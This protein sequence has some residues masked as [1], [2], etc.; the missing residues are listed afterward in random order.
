MT[1][2]APGLDA[3]DIT[4][5]L[6]G[7]QLGSRLMRQ[8]QNELESDDNEADA[9]DT[10]DDP[11][12]IANDSDSDANANYESN[13]SHDDSSDLEDE[14][15]D[16]I[17]DTQDQQ[18]LEQ[19]TFLGD[20]LQSLRELKR[21]K[22]DWFDFD[23]DDLVNKYLKK[24]AECMKMVHDELNLVGNLIQTYT[25]IKVINVSDTKPIKINKIVTSLQT[26]SEELITK[27][28]KRNKVK[29]LQQIA[30]VK[31]IDPTYPKVYLQI[32]I[33]NSLL[34]TAA[35]N[36]VNKSPIPMEIN[37]DADDCGDFFTHTCHSFPEFSDKRQQ[38]EFRCIDPGHTL[39][40]MRSQISR[41][42]YKFCSK[43][44]FVRVSERNHKVL[45]KSIL[46]DRL[47]RQSI[48]IA[49][50]FFSIDVQEELAKN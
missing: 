36:W 8:A 50:R 40:N 28:V 35:T 45:P 29:T 1:S 4:N 13:F 17:T 21:G 5:L 20:L 25:G 47:D 19:Q 11:D 34:E 24:P 7:S 15:A 31:L 12:Y 41:Y 38:R 14:L 30:R 43:A 46:E 32:V 23:V 9:D 44:A 18:L 33:A 3:D 48:R 10:N 22:I 2:N 37:V 49:K 27:T 42:G 26:S 16:L 39:A 6:R